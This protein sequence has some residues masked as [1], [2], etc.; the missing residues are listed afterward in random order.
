MKNDMKI[1]WK[2]EEKE[3]GT[4]LN[5][6]IIGGKEDM[7]MKTCEKH[8]RVIGIFNK[9]GLFRLS[10]VCPECTEELLKKATDEMKEEKKEKEE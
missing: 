1:S 7:M 2:T 8:N 4:H 10:I 3:D 6:E 9:V 5:I